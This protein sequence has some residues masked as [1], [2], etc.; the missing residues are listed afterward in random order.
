MPHRST[1]GCCRYRTL[2]STVL[3]ASLEASFNRF[4]VKENLIEVVPWKNGEIII[5]D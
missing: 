2:T 5:G 4:D 3:T 1:R